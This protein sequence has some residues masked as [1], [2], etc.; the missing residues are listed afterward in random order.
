MLKDNIKNLVGLP[1]KDFER[2]Y[3]GRLQSEDELGVMV[4]ACSPNTQ[5]AE[6]GGSL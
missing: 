3:N 2:F 5:D 4:H 6:A 1:V